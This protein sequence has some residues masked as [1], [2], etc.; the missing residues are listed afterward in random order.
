MQNNTMN[1]RRQTLTT[2]HSNFKYSSTQSQNKIP[3]F[4][5]NDIMDEDH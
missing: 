4:M 1:S 5:K 2:H 3:D